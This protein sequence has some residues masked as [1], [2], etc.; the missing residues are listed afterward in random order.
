M[1]TVQLA[2]FMARGFAA[3]AIPLAL[4]APGTAYAAASHLSVAVWTEGPDAA[5]AL[6]QVSDALRSNYTVANPAD[7]RGAMTKEGQRGPVTGALQ[8]PKKRPDEI[9]RFRAA[10]R[11][12]NLDGVVVVMTS[13]SKKSGKSADAI[14]I[15]ASSHA[16]KVTHVGADEVTADAAQ[17]GLADVLPA[18]AEEPP[19]PVA[20][21]A[22][23]PA[24]A[25]PATEA[26]PSEAPE[27]DST[28]ARAR[29]P[30]EVGQELFQLSLAFEGAMRHFSYTDGLTRNLR[31]YDLNAAPAAAAEGAIYPLA[32]TRIAV[33]RDIGAVFGYAR[34][35]ALQSA[36]SDGTKYSTDW[37]RYYV[38]ARYRIRTGSGASPIFGLTG[39]YGAE[40]FEFGGAPNATLPSVA[41]QFVQASADARVPIGRF[42]I[43]ADVGYLFVLSGGAVADR[44]PKSSIGGIEA[45]LGASFT[46]IPSLEVRLAASYRRFFYTMNP[47]PGD[48]YV[49]GGA[50]DE[51]SGLQGGL[52]YVF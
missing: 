4:V 1:N 18:K 3:A 5:A 7:L 6:T 45:K 26:A 11:D 16:W 9:A 52:A 32:T 24:P 38:G 15:D 44:F 50:L 29:R 23:P 14:V 36:T 31:N 2:G 19:A 22:A 35:F 10:A 8:N 41:Y 34:A 39:A 25:E 46:V 40:S 37:S 47:T 51:L 28:S 21:P 17:A 43:F 48:G 42:S 20:E 13:R 27:R 33:A 12:A 30:H 49:A